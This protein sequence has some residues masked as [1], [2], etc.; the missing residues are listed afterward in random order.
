MP[1]ARQARRRRLE[2]VRI[3]FIGCGGIAQG[4][5]RRVLEHGGAEIVGLCDPSAVMI[6]RTLRN[7]P[8]LADVP[9]HRD[10]KDLLKHGGLDA[11]EIHTPH[12]LHYE[13]IMAGFKSGL[14]VLTEKPM[15]CTVAHAKKIIAKARTSRRVMLV[16]YQRHYQGEFRYMRQ[17][18]AQGKLGTVQMISAFQGQN[19]MQGTTG[20]WRQDPKLSG[21]GQLND[22]GSHLIDIILWIT[23]LAVAQVSA[24][25]EFFDRKVDINSALSIEFTNG[26]LANLTICG[27]APRWMEDLTILGSSGAFCFRDGQLTHHDLGT[28][29]VN[30]VSGLRNFGN[31]DANF[32]DAIRSGQEVQSPPLCGLRVIELTEAAWKSAAR[33][34]RPVRM[35]PRER[36]GRKAR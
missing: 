36:A 3:G 27:N 35:N 22:S 23:G 10:Y 14:H 1:R 2:K 4:H 32:I 34:G 29:A 13:Q 9:V 28:G 12:T 19:W 30:L 33:G 31:P 21:G 25:I 15:V 26:A 24:F 20:K 16:S 5:L 11:I 8:Q 17:M 7:F 18:I 6:E